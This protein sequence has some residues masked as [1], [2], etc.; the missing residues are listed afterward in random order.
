MLT[1]IILETG[2]KLLNI[3]RI[4]VPLVRREFTGEITNKES[5]FSLE[6]EPANPTKSKYKQL[7]LF[8]DLEWSVG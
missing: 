8:E 2:L 3:D 4:K 7:S 6:N 1:L 5:L